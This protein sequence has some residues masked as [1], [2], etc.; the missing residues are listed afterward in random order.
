MGICLTCRISKEIISYST[1]WTHDLNQ[2]HTG[3][4]IASDLL[5]TSLMVK[6]FWHWWLVEGARLYTPSKTVT[7]KYDLMLNLKSDSY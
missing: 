7:S 6:V 4:H 1:H 2:M 5:I 3:V